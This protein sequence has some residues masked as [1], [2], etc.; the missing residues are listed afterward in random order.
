VPEKNV[1]K[2]V[3]K[4]LNQSEAKKQNTVIKTTTI[5][6]NKKNKTNLP[7]SLA[8]NAPFLSKGQ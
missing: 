1:N 3:N 5:I 8:S 6:V 2:N 7:R 4:Q